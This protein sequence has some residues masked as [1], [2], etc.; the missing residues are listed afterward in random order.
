VYGRSGPCILAYW[1][2]PDP[3]IESTTAGF[4]QP[5]TKSFLLRRKSGKTARPALGG[6]AG[7]NVQA[8]GDQS[9]NSI[10]HFGEAAIN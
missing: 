6:W 9:E 3:A 1:H 2:L 7:S 10:S 5:N 8:A 4:A